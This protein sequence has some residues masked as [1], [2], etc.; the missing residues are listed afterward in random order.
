MERAAIID[1]LLQGVVQSG[2]GTAAAIPGREVAGK[3]G[4]TENYG[5]AWFVG[6]TPQIVAAVWV[7]YPNSLVPMRTLY[8]GSP[9]VGGT[10]P[11]LIWKAFMTK[12]LAYLKLPPET[13]PAPPSMSGSPVSVTFRNG[14]L[15]LDNGNCKNA[16]TVDFY[17]GTAPTAMS[18]CKHNEVEVPDV[19]GST[20][21]AAK[22]RLYL[23]PL[24]TRIVYKPAKPGQ[25]VDI[26]IGQIPRNGTLS[27]FDHVT[28][29]VPKALQGVIP[30]LVGLTIAQARAKLAPLKLVVGLTGSR[31][32]KVVSQQ[33]TWNVASAPGMRIVL[34]VKPSAP[35]PAK[36]GKHG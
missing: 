34:G 5:D 30:R 36:P 16:A 33:P 7:G 8:R 23:Q 1:S 28:L 27:S 15:E 19:R 22:A 9:V 26:V 10:Y 31:T 24:L 3:T 13:F 20:L 2:T 17:P 35:K 29:V 21:T 18:N 12:A 11:A 14:K 32:G 6:F 25:R 4:T